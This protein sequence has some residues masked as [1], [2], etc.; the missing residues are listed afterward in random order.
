MLFIKSK[1]DNTH[2]IKNVPY[3]SIDIFDFKC[4]G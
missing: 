4:A 1:I 3:F 2:E